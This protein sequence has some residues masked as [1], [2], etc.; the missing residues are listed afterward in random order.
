MNNKIVNKQIPIEKIVDIANYFEDYKEKYDKLFEE[1]REKNKNLP[2]IERRP[3]YDNVSAEIKYTI[4]FHNGQTIK[5]KDF[6]WFISNLNN[7]KIIKEIEL[8]LSIRYFSKSDKDNLNSEYNSITASVDFRDAGMNLQYSDVIIN[9]NTTNQERESNNIYS[10][11]MN[12]LEDTEDRYNNTIKHRKIRTQ[13]FTISVGIILSY[14]L[15]IILRINIDKIPPVLA[16]YLDNKYIL[17]FGQWFIAIV[18]GNVLSYWYM[19]MLYKP[20]LPYAKYA[21]YNSSTHRSVYR[22]DISDYLE[23]SEVHFGKYWDAEKRRKRIEDIYKVTK[24]ILLVQLVISAILF[25]VMK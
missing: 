3:E 10:T 14:I 4:A 2:F 6:N 16:E 13:C 7:T 15:Y 12:T 8:Y 23:H 9:V 5:E 1:D 18:F 21:G 25:F 19:L 20:L 11:I 22:D 17:V 24:I